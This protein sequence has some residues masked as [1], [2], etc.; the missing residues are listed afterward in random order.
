MRDWLWTQSGRDWLETKGVRDWL[1]TKGVESWL[2]TE[3]GRDWLQTQS[4]RDWVQSQHGRDWLQ[5]Y[6]GMGWLQTQAGHDWLQTQ[7]G[8]DWLQTQGGR[9]WLQT[10]NGEDWLQTE[11]GRDWLQTPHAEAWPFM[12]V[13]VTIVEFWS[14]LEAVSQ[15]PIDP[16]LPCLPAFQV[17]QHFK[18][19][20]DFLM[21]PAFLAL[22]H[23]NVSTF[24]S[25]QD[26]LPDVEII[27][28]M[29]AFVNVANKG[30]ERGQ[31][32]SDALKYACH[33]W[34]IHLARAPRPWDAMLGHVFH[35]FWYDH[36]LYW[37]EMQ[38]CSK[39]LR[40][41]LAVLH[42]GEKLAGEYS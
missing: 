21:F 35:S 26:H 34:A 42:E 17:I 36:L 2:Q 23:H 4:G 40:A 33:N 1:E 14:A 15:Y 8:R 25:P 18:S 29:K 7:N 5:G 31:S 13:W 38:W 11:S 10:Y 16:D 24:A 19:L 20:P 3:S 28:A 27:R 41:C 12:G 37:L 9:D 22:R 32:T 6:R 39:G 30:R